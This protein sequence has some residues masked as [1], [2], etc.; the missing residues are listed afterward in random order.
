MLLCEGAWRE[1]S[2]Q[3]HC[4]EVLHPH[5]HGQGQPVLGLEGEQ[6][7]VEGACRRREHPWGPTELGLGSGP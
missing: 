5:P 2:G 7:A 4:S 1:E 6:E 3:G